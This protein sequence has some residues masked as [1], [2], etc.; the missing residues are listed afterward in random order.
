[1]DLKSNKKI[2]ND[3]EFVHYIENRVKQDKISA[4]AVLGQIK[5]LNL[6][7][8]TSISKTTLYRYIELGIFDNIKIQKRKE[9]YRKTYIKRAPKG[10]LPNY[11]CYGYRLSDET[12]VTETGY[13][14]RKVEI[15]PEEAEV[16]K[17][18]F[19]L[20][21]DGLSMTDIVHVLN[22]KKFLHR[23]RTVVG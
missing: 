10:D 16:V 20:Y 22:H 9:R 18:I 7:F 1:M 17:E 13:K 6:Q 4:C 15:I 8:K 2:G 11:A 14:R 21:A 3:F 19:R 12:E 23:G 5:H